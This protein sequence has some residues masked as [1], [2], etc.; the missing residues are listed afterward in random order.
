[1]TS[2]TTGG[3]QPLP[4][5]GAGPINLQTAP[6]IL[7]P[8]DVDPE[9]F[10]HALG[11]A[12]NVGERIKNGEIKLEDLPE[13]QKAEFNDALAFLKNAEKTK[14]KAQDVVAQLQNK[15]PSTLT[16]EEKEALTNALVVLRNAEAGKTNAFGDLKPVNSDGSSISVISEGT[17]S[18]V[19]KL[20]TSLQGSNFDPAVVKDILAKLNVVIKTDGSPGL[21]PPGVVASSS[22]VSGETEG[23]VWFSGNFLVNLRYNLLDF[24]K[25]NRDSAMKY[26]EMEASLITLYT[27][28]MNEKAELTE[29]SYDKQA[30]M[31]MFEMIGAAVSIGLSTAQVG[32]VAGGALKGGISGMRN[33]TGTRVPGPAASLDGATAG[34]PP[35]LAPTRMQKAGG[36]F[37][38]AA[39][40]AGAASHAT[41][42]MNSLSQSSS[43]FIS[44]A[45]K[46]ILFKEIG[47]IE[48][49]KVHVEAEADLIKKA[50][51][52]L[53][54]TQKEGLDQN[55]QFR[56]MLK[57]IS[58]ET[59]RIFNWKL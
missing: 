16:S 58:E 6:V 17:L 59:A 29:K 15:D 36:A 13:D 35:T 40:G 42:F 57:Q 50:M 4:P 23:N 48:R 33:A 3:Q 18:E 25:V 56:A 38:G 2:V 7:N 51:D 11:I 37:S 52:S 32:M 19:D 45:A 53:S 47:D 22:Q 20:L 28:V 12:S 49:D 27:D 39:S 1:M 30:E 43:S 55:D 46:M 5:P 24:E 8:D 21:T 41:M 26:G 9:T 34:P 10:A 31:A 44:N 54:A 14:L